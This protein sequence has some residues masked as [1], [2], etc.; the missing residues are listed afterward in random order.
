MCGIAGYFGPKKNEPSNNQIE[1]CMNL[2]KRRGPDYQHSS[3]KNFN[4]ISSIMLHSRLS[5]IDPVINSKQPM[6]DKNGILSF[7][8]EIYNYL[9]LISKYNLKNLKTKSDTEVLLKYLNLQKESLPKDDL[10]GMW[11]FAYLRKI[12]M[13]LVLCKD[14][15]GEKPLYYLFKNKSLYYG[16]NINYIYALYNKN[17]KLNV[18]KISAFISYGFKSLF[19]ND[20]TFFKDIKTLN[21]SESLTINTL[22][23]IKRK[24]IWKKKPNFNF[25]IKNYNDAKSELI[26][27]LK[28]SFS[29]RLRSD[30]QIS[31]LLSGGIDSSSIVSIAKNFCNKYL[32]CY[33]ISTDDKN[34]DESKR[35][36]LLCKSLGIKTKYISM[37]K[38]DSYEFLENIIQDTKFPLSSI[39]YLVYAHLNKAIK[40][41]GHRVLLSGLG[42]D[43]IFAGYYTHQ[44]NYLVSNFHDKNFNKYYNDWNKYIK[45]L[46]RSKILSDFKYY[47]KNSKKQLP[48]FHEKE[49]VKKFIK[50]K[51]T[52]KINEVKFTSNFFRN[53]LSVDLFRDTIPPQIL[54]SDQVSMHYSIENRSPF[55]SKEIFDFAHSLQDNFLINNGFGK[56]ILRDSLQGLLPN[57]VLKFREKIGFYA[58]INKFFKTSS[59]QFK[60]RLF[61]SDLINK[62]INLKE[63]TKVLNKDYMNNS[64][65]KFIFCILNLA[66]LEQVK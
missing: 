47:R 38:F 57:E 58:N 20:E 39:S 6:E 25:K 19:L 60:D 43:E 22:L 14:R 49:E 32:K 55:L 24:K 29:R 15:F 64:E 33:S 66:I 10:D 35:I 54:S 41:D 56:A 37:D 62:F 5:I 12:K 52:K 21:S 40:E 61:Q 23:N 2:M 53:Q 65:A 28:K 27:I 7:N 44:M 42:G 63:I 50:K 16:S 45:P 30:F 31:C 4:D 13:E 11:S 34:Y 36:D 48:S 3:K 59:K 26:E 8:G 46:V 18:D 17:E 1:S 9:E 51:Y